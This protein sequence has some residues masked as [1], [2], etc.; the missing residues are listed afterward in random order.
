MN[1]FEFDEESFNE[2]I[3]QDPSK[4]KTIMEDIGRMPSGENAGSEKNKE[5]SDTEKKLQNLE[6]EI[7]ELKKA[8]EDIVPRVET[9]E[10]SKKK[11]E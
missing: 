11:E 2:A 10:Q 4:I 9:L 3:K 6:K 7:A 8:V 1:K 5:T